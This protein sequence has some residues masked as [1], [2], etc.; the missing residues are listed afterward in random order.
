MKRFA[1]VVWLLLLAIPVA[2][3]TLFVRSLPGGATLLVS[4]EPDAK[5][6]VIEAFFRVGVADENAAGESGLSA[7]LTRTWASGGANRSASR[8]A[9]DIGQF[10][11]LGVFQT[12]DYIELWTQSD[13]ADSE[14]AAQT[15]LSNVVAAPVFPDS[16][17]AEAKKEV[18]QDRTIRADALLGHALEKLRARVFA[19]SP[20]GRDLLG[21]AENA[22]QLTVAGLRRFHA[23]TVGSDA[24]RAVFVVAGRMGADEAERLVRSALAAGDFAPFRSAET[25]KK[26]TTPALAVVPPGLRPLDLRRAAP[27]RLSLVGYAAPG[28]RTGATRTATLH[29]LDAVM[30]AGKDCRLFGLRDRLRDGETPI[31]YDI[32]SR[33]E[34]GR[35]QSLWVAYVSG[36][37]GTTETATA[38]IIGECRAVSDGSRPITDAELT[39]AKSLLIGK[40]RRER[41]RLTERASA[42]GVA[43]VMG[44]GAGFE[45]NYAERIGAVTLADVQELAREMFAANAGSVTTGSP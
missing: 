5:S 35:D 17:V 12:A 16:A 29:V 10:G 4:Q 15:L 13:Y 23:R 7:L 27:T 22:G 40:H 42:L 37:E 20:T 24:S 19:L 41:Q 21:D 8:I 36:V 44:L 18:T 33:L 31:G 34:A 25:K 39:R 14:I 43:Q 2:A 30:G 28:T 26:E 3:Q 32:T 9:R 11:T 45:A 6:V 38:R 1:L